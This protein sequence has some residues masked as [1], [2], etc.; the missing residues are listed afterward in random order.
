M[1]SVCVWEV[2]VGPTFSGKRCGI[3]AY[4][5]ERQLTKCA[6]TWTYNV[7]RT[8]MSCVKCI[9]LVYPFFNNKYTLFIHDDN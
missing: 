2:R 6:V 4:D 3:K 8:I 7:Q 1:V 5:G 9:R